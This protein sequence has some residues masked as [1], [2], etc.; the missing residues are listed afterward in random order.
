M[1]T[2][3]RKPKT[4]CFISDEANPSDLTYDI[5]GWLDLLGTDTSRDF[6]DL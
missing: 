4:L 2:V 3:R 1:D 5:N 6:Q